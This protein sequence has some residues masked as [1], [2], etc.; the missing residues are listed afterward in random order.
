MTNALDETAL[1]QL[2]TEA[3]TFQ[4]W[5][6]K[7]VAIETLK[8]L[9][10]LLKF[11]PTAA[12]SCPARFIFITS[13]TAKQRLK[14]CLSE[15]NIGKTM[16]APV[17]VIIAQDL[18]FYEQLP[19]LY[20]FT[21]ARAWFAGNEAL[22]QESAMRNSSLQGAYLM[23]AARAV[24]LDCGPMS[25]FDATKLNTE[26][27]AGQNLKA[28]FLCN[29]GYGDRSHLHARAPRLNFDEACRIL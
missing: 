18:E 1:Q 12:N 29:L 8:Q 21:D 5:Q 24:G 26:F 27:F 28:N 2:F 25:G 6:N 15:G 16:S 13:D 11:G 22:I 10:N 9:Y 4:H 3:R 19:K 7:P 23:L 20:P 17:T 14:P